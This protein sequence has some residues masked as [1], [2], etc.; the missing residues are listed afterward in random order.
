MLALALL[1]QSDAAMKPLV[2]FYT[3]ALGV[4]WLLWAPWVAHVQGVRSIPS[5]PYLHLVG[6]LGPAVAALIVLARSTGAGAMRQLVRRTFTARAA[7]QAAIWAVAVPTLVF[8]AGLL[9]MA[10]S[11][12]WIIRWNVIRV[13]SDYPT[14]SPFVYALASLVFYGFG[15]EIGWRGFL[16]PH[17]RL[18]HR[19]LAASLLVVPF[20]AFWHLPL[21]FATD[22]YRAMGVGGAA[23]W[24]A[25]LVSGSLLTAWLTDRARGSILPAAVLHAVLDIYFLAD[26]GAPIQ[27]VLGAAVTITGIAVAVIQARPQ[28]AATGA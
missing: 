10:A 27:T 20:W 15:E 8:V 28:R 12:R 6:S 24:L 17:L 2:V 16:Y 19:P 23:G 11:S 1:L 5:S 14:L 3:T 4:S 18:R 9:G 7:M 21:F 22:S 25:S 13:V 26:V